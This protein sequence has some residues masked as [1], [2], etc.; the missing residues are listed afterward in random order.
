MVPPG[1][2][3]EALFLRQFFWQRSPYS[4]A[5]GVGRWRIQ[6]CSD[7]EHSVLVS[8]L[9]AVSEAEWIPTV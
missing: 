6:Q 7:N 2:P 3:G 4:T 9:R 5:H 8:E 1:Y